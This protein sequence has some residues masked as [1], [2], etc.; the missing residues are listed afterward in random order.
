MI[1]VPGRAGG[2]CGARGSAAAGARRGARVRAGRPGPP[3]DDRGALLPELRG[4]H[5][6]PRAQRHPGELAR[7]RRRHALH[8][9]PADRSRPRGAGAADVQAVAELAVHAGTRLPVARRLRD[10]GLAVDRHRAVP[11]RHRDQDLRAAAQRQGDADGEAAAGGHHDH[12][13]R[14]P[15]RA[16]RAGIGALAAGRHNDGS[17]ARPALPG[18]VRLRRAA[19]RRRQPQ[20]RQRR[21]H[22]LPDRRHARL[23][24]RL[25]RD[26]AADQRH[27]RGA[28]GA[29]RA[30]GHRAADVRVPGQRVLQSRRRLHA[31][32]RTRPDRR[33]DVLPRRGPAGRGP[34]DLH[35]STP[36]RLVADRARLHLEPRNERDA[37][38]RRDGRGGGGSRRR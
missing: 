23:L 12:P 11:R 16:R 17:R 13:D 19:L 18:S 35:G 15:G 7:P 22:R 3:R 27:D 2:L 33:A 21:V 9:G 24:L 30:G 26:A 34:V 20:R 28:Q 14:R 38:E 31:R 25:L 4:D 5:R 10:L 6:Q 1:R 36:G 32:R 8:V 29:R 37:R